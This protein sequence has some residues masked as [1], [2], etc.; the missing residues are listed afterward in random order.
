[1]NSPP[2]GA[3]DAGEP[4][5]PD[6]SATS[7]PSSD[8]AVPDAPADAAL[9]DA[10]GDAVGEPAFVPVIDVAPSNSY[11]NVGDR[12]PSVGHALPVAVQ[13]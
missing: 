1:M 2:S 8:A 11:A 12:V 13:F 5:S 10:T 9:R 4:S 3:E 6:G 7:E